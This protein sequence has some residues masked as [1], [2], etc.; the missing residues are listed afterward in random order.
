[1][2]GIVIEYAPPTGF[3]LILFCGVSFP[4][5]SSF[6][7]E[8]VHCEL[9][10]PIALFLC[11]IVYHIIP[12]FLFPPY[13]HIRSSCVAFPP[14]GYRWCSTQQDSHRSLVARFRFHSST[15]PPHYLF[16]RL[17]LQ[18]LPLLR[19]IASLVLLPSR[20]LRNATVL[21]AG[22]VAVV[23]SSRARLP[24]RAVRCC[25]RMLNPCIMI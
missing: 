6:H 20:I 9:P 12:S 14:R 13:S 2:S 10:L 15:P 19:Q 7:L 8:I 21:T 17:L 1:M 24:C 25:R 11:I 4:I 18:L 23:R 16:Q 5:L 3:G 22:C